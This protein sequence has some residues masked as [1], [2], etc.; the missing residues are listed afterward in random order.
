MQLVGHSALNNNTLI[1]PTFFKFTFTSFFLTQ[2]VSSKRGAESRRSPAPL[3]YFP[4][5]TK[6]PRSLACSA[7]ATL[8]YLNLFSTTPCSD[9]NKV[10]VALRSK[11]QAGEKK[12]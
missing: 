1:F 2:S 8:S 4:S 7:S 11:T 10:A 9:K 12:Q 3:S 6:P 5:G